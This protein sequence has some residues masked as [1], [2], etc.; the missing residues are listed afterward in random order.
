[1]DNLANMEFI[2]GYTNVM[3]LWKLVLT[4]SILWFYFFFKQYPP[5]I[6]LNEYGSTS[7]GADLY[8]LIELSRRLNFTFRL[9]NLTNKWHEWIISNHSLVDII[10][11]GFHLTYETSKICDNLYPYFIEQTSIMTREPKNPEYQADRL[12][13]PFDFYIWMAILFSLII[14]PLSTLIVSHLNPKGS[15]SI[16]DSYLIWL[17]ILLKQNVLNR[18]KHELRPIIIAWILAT[19][20]LSTFYAGCLL[21]MITIPHDHRINSLRR[22]SRYCKQGNMVVLT[23]NNT[24]TMKIVQV[25]GQITYI[26]PFLITLSIEDDGW[27][28]DFCSN[29]YS[30]SSCWS[31]EW[32]H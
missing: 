19:F 28:T 7:Q 32:C 2:V 15:Y 18:L 1:M 13:D 16:Q 17:Y 20:I 21:S 12:L 24:A 25:C 30:S 9:I 22:L 8:L 29:S 14:L 26:C 6:G 10:M 27:Q 5:Y 23:E 3:F 31:S 4:N 11:G